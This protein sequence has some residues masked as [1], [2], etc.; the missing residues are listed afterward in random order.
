[1]KTPAPRDIGLAIL[2]ILVFAIGVAQ[3]SLECYAKD[4]LQNYGG[5]ILWAGHYVEK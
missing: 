1:M 2:S 3:I 4:T 5:V